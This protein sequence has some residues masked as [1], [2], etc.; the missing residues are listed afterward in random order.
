[1]K[2]TWRVQEGRTARQG[3]KAIKRDKLVEEGKKTTQKQNVPPPAPPGCFE[4]VPHASVHGINFTCCQQG[5]WCSIRGHQQPSL[6]IHFSASLRVRHASSERSVTTYGERDPSFRGLGNDS[7]FSPLLFSSSDFQKLDG[8]TP[9][10]EN[11]LFCGCFV[12]QTRICFFFFL[13]FAGSQ[14]ILDGL[15]ANK[16]ILGVY[17][18]RYSIEYRFFLFRWLVFSKLLNHI[19][20]AKSQFTKFFNK[21]GQFEGLRQIWGKESF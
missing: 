13:L 18:H 21:V 12:D 10:K 17:P 9:V 8:M 6:I 7:T 3:V 1:M 14:W 15:R 16:K 5:E 11:R 2:N 19:V 20:G 4:L